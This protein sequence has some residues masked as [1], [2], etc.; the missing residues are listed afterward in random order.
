MT[1]RL[2]AWLVDGGPSGEREI[3]AYAAG[4]M[5]GIAVAT[6]VLTFVVGVSVI[7]G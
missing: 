6:V 7:S 2:V 3:L 5:I 1:S 4:S